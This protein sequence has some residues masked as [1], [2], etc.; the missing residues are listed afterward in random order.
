MGLNFYF[1]FSFFLYWRHHA[2]HGILVPQ[3][4]IEPKPMPIAVEAGVLTTGPPGKS[5]VWG[6]MDTCICMAEAL[7]SAPE[8]ITTLLIGYTPA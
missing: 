5:G 6:R 7:C 4:G 8:P 2:A 1:Y 3:P